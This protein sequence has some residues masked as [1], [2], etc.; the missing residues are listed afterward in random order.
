MSK[1]NPRDWTTIAL[2]KE[3][4]KELEAF[5]KTTDNYDCVLKR[6]ICDAKDNHN[7]KKGLWGDER[8][9]LT[10]WIDV[11]IGLFV[12]SIVYALL[13][14]VLNAHI[15]KEAVSTASVNTPQ[16]Y[17]DNVSKFQ[18][19]LG[20]FPIVMFFGVFV[21]AFVRVQRRGGEA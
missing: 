7:K 2:R 1:F 11:L 9:A 12:F 21:Y 15:I 8:A 19:L 13:G 17:F 20:V 4:K 3:T 18:L 6:I 14:D 5:K 16:A 10:I